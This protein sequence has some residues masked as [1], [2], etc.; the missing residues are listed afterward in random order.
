MADNSSITTTTSAASQKLPQIQD[1]QNPNSLSSPP[2]IDSQPQQ[3]QQI[4]IQQQQQQQQQQLNNNNMVSPSNFQIQQGIQRSQNMQRL[5]QMQQQ[6]GQAAVAAAALRHQQQ[7]QAMY[8]QVNFS[9]AQIQQQQQQM[10]RPGQIGQGGGGQLPMLSGQAMQFNLQSQLLA[11]QIKNVAKGEDRFPIP[12]TE[13][14]GSDVARDTGGNDD[15]NTWFGFA[16]ENEWASLLYT[17]E[18]EPWAVKTTTVAPSDRDFLSSASLLAATAL[19][20]FSN[21]SEIHDPDSAADISTSTATPNG[22]S[23]ATVSD[24]TANFATTTT[25]TSA[26]A[27]AAAAS[28]VIPEDG[29]LC[30]S[31]VH[32]P[33]RFTIRDCCI[34]HDN[35]WK[36]KSRNGSKQSTSWKRK[37][38][39]LVSQVDSLGRLDPEVEELLLEMADDFIDSVMAITCYNICMQS[40]EA[41]EIFNIGI[42]GFVATPR[43]LTFLYS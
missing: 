27:A 40:G 8:G 39:D 1:P 42:Q 24:T 6:Y 19:F 28:A 34:W 13:Y 33:D 31:K 12:Y 18:T 9:G 25:T 15:R 43:L 22:Y 41:S 21:A 10:S 2:P 23:A 14:V 20:N 17:A 36:F 7:Q 4:H 5:G 30:S 38:Q 26:S 3:Q 29:G 32:E 35:A 37:I 11:G 16:A